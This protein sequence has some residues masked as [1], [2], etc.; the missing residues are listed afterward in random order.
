MGG[1]A[2]LSNDGVEGPS[3]AEDSSVE[4]GELKGILVHRRGLILGTAVLLAVLALVYGLVTPPLYSATAEILI[5]P[6]DRQIVSNAI[7]PSTLSPDGGITQVE[8]QVA[9][10]QSNSVLLRAIETANL[11]ADSHFNRVSFLSRLKA[12]LMGQPLDTERTQDEATARTLDQLRRNLSVKRADK[13][14]VIDVTVTAQEPA[15]A[16]RLANIIADSYLADQSDARA[17]ASRE[18][19]GALTARLAEQRAAVQAAEDA[20]EKYRNDNN[21]ISAGGVLVSDQ[22]LADINT[23]LANAR[24]VT[25]YQKA[26]VD[27]IQS[28]IASGRTPDA[29]GEV[30]RSTVISSLRDREAALDQRISEMT[31]QLGARHPTLQA[32]QAQKVGIERQIRTELAR[33]AASATADY[34]WAKA[35]ED[36]L[37][38]RQAT[39]ESQTR[40]TDQVQVRLRELERDRDAVREVYANYL[41]RS[42]EVREQS[43]ID[44]TNARVISRAIVPIDKKGP[45]TPLLAVAG[46]FGGLGLGAA[47]AL[48]VEYASPTALSER[49]VRQAAGAPVL[50]VLPGSILRGRQP[51]RSGRRARN[52][53]GLLGLVLRRL[54]TSR[55]ERRS[56]VSVVLLCS[57]EADAR[58]R[59][60]VASELAATAASRGERVLLID[61]DL[62]HSR[63]QGP[64][65]LIDV[66]SG[67]SRLS[68]AV[69]DCYD[70]QVRF[71]A[72]GGDRAVL[73]ERDALRFTERLWMDAADSFDIV[74]VDAGD[75]TTNLRASALV[76]TAEDILVVARLRSTPLEAIRAQTT[77]AGVMGRDLSG[78]LVIGAGR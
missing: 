23:Q 72:I 12:R 46:F 5:D 1:W 7:N 60:R 69:Q 13:V 54:S 26:R 11:T 57:A 32:A 71:M 66:L 59:G 30:M 14:L 36:E 44:S 8:S 63:A 43:N 28:I 48:L 27:Q 31:L 78:A 4:L 29:T 77:A 51:V 73:K 20:V 33:I 16:A 52:L 65:G 45:P 76:A 41:K 61:A 37:K 22:A 75:L 68:N 38:T 2:Q 70:D 56:P 49:Q 15:E 24:N 35:A 34:N 50:A 62:M 39:L 21:L 40:A 25:A 3:H 53:S 19:A 17:D 42:Q 64:A 18:A 9:V 47:L 10:V 55:R 74:V 6:R 58:A 67:E